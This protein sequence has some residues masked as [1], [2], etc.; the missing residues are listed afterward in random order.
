MI[1]EMTVSVRVA[2]PQDAVGLAQLLA[3]LLGQ[4]LS[5]ALKSAL[6]TNLLRL[7]SSPGHT[8]L[9]AESSTQLAGFI[10]C[11]TRW[12]LF[13]DGPVG[14]IDQVVIGEKWQ[15]S[16][17]S[18]ALLEQAMGACQALGCKEL[19]VSLS[20]GSLD[21]QDLLYEVGFTA[22]PRGRFQLTIA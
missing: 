21:I 17:V 10:S 5:P 18:H 12:G 1:P 8:L 22:S 2:R 11:W 15:A 6:N 20:E 4:P 7:L 3:E 9:I 14:C 16:S 13:D 19:E